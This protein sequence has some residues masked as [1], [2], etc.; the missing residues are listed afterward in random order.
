MACLMMM[1]L[2]GCAVTGHGSYCDIANPIYIS[3]DDHLT[4]DTARAIL[5]NNETWRKLC[6]D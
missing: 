2:N 1:L 6:R 4:N 5:S 3:D